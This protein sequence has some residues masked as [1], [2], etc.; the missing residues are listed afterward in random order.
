LDG[1]LLSVTKEINARLDRATDRPIAVALSGG[2]DSLALLCA[3][4]IYARQVGRRVVAITIDHQLSSE[5]SLWTQHAKLNSE[6]LGADWRG[7]AWIG[8]KPAT[9]LPAAARDARHKLVADVARQEGAKVVLFGH[10]ADDVI[11]ATDMRATDTPGLSLPKTWAPSPVWPE[12]RGLA[13]FRPMLAV[14][15]ETLR[16]ALRM[17]GLTW[18]EDPANLD[19]RFAR[20]RARLRLTGSEKVACSGDEPMSPD[21]SRFACSVVFSEWGDAEVD[22]DALVQLPPLV[23]HRALSML[24]TCVSGA[25]RLPRPARVTG[26][27]ERLNDAGSVTATLGGALVLGEGKALRVLR[28]AGDDRYVRRSAENVFDG[29]FESNAAEDLQWLKGQMGHLNPADRLRLHDVHP[30]LRPGL[31]VWRDPDGTVHLAGCQ[32]GRGPTLRSLAR[33][34]FR[35]ACGV[36]QRES[37]LDAL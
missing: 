34:R 5:S 21:L 25:E 7:R 2:G 19:P 15:R 8:E 32:A 11:E 24:V 33:G 16:S 22:R 3:T 14:R 17:Q 18:V 35:L 26:L 29:R 27:L 30:R 10:T 13:V 20:S 37:E 9:G 31:P 1:P 12:G 28:E 6:K 23:G 4:V 36:V